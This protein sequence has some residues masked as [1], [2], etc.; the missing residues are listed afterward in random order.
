M[1]AAQAINHHLYQ[2]V[3]EIRHILP[4]YSAAS[5]IILKCCALYVYYISHQSVKQWLQWFHL[6]YF[7]VFCFSLCHYVFLNYDI[8]PQ[9]Y[10][11]YPYIHSCTYCSLT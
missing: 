7:F 1:S 10:C 2:T 11:L 6:D 8:I 5:V 9:C 4:H 3:Q